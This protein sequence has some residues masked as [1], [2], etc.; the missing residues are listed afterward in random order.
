M[1][2]FFTLLPQGIK[3][4]I[5]LPPYTCTQ[6]KDWLD[7]ELYASIAILDGEYLFYLKCICVP[8]IINLL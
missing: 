3:K 7:K 6:Q 8:T 5:I 1:L 4:I 2:H